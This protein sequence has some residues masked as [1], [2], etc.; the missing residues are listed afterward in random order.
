MVQLNLVIVVGGLFQALYLWIPASSVLLLALGYSNALTEVLA[1][2]MLLVYLSSCWCH[3]P[4]DLSVVELSSVVDILSVAPFPCKSYHSPDRA[5]LPVPQDTLE[6]ND[7]L[8]PRES[9]SLLETLIQTQMLQ[10]P[11]SSLYNPQ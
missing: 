5:V 4:I 11:Y 1:L 9:D 10:P 8:H 7:E 6:D 3:L 2:G